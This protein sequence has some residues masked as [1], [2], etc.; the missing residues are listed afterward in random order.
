MSTSGLSGGPW[1]VQNAQR[2]VLL[3]LDGERV[4]WLS[5]SG[6][7][8]ASHLSGRN[9][10]EVRAPDASHDTRITSFV[11]GPS[12]IFFITRDPEGDSL[13]CVTH[14]GRAE[15]IL[16]HGTFSDH[17][18][19]HQDHLYWADLGRRGLVAMPC[20]GG[21]PALLAPLSPAGAGA[22]T[23]LEGEGLVAVS[24]GYVLWTSTLAEPPQ[25]TPLTDE[26][27]STQRSPGR[28]RLAIFR[29][30]MD[31]GPTTVLV[32][33]PHGITD[34]SATD[35]AAVWTASFA[36]EIGMRG[37]IESMTLDGSRT[38]A[39]LQVPDPE[40]RVAT[41]GEMAFVLGLPSGW[42]YPLEI[43]IGPGEGRPLRA[44][45]IAAGRL[46]LVYATE[47]GDI[48]ALA[49]RG[50]PED[51]RA[52]FRR[53]EV[54]A[55]RPEGCREKAA[56]GHETG[57]LDELRAR[58]RQLRAE[59]ANRVP[60]FPYSR[61]MFEP[62]RA[63]RGGDIASDLRT[64]LMDLAL[65]RRGAC[66][67]LTGAEGS[68]K[69]FV[70]H[71]VSA[72]LEARAD[73]P[74]PL[75][76][77]V[78]AH[79]GNAR[80]APTEWAIDELIRAH[81][82]C[83][84]LEGPAARL[85]LE[86]VQRGDVA[87]LLDH[88]DRGALRGFVPSAVARACAALPA[89]STVFVACRSASF[90]TLS[91]REKVLAE[92]SFDTRKADDW[93]LEPFD[94][95]QIWRALWRRAPEQ[96]AAR[97]ALVDADPELLSL[98]RIPFFL[99]ALARLT[100]AHNSH[101]RSSL[102]LADCLAEAAGEELSPFVRFITSSTSRPPAE[103][104]RTPFVTADET[105]AH[106]YFHPLLAEWMCAEAMTIP[107]LRTDG[108][109]E[110]D[111]VMDEMS[112]E[113]WPDQLLRLFTGCVTRVR[114]PSV[115]RHLSEQERIEYERRTGLSTEARNDAVHVR[116]A[117]ILH[118]RLSAWARR[119]A[120]PANPKATEAANA[121]A[122]LRALEALPPAAE[123]GS[124]A[125]P[126]L[127]PGLRIRYVDLRNRDLRGR[128][129]TSSDLSF[130]NL[131]GADLRGAK[132]HGARL[133]GANLL[134]ATLED[135]A[136]DG[137]DTFGAALRLDAPPTETI[138]HHSPVS[139]VSFHPNGL[140]VLTAHWD[141]S[142]KGA[143]QIW[144][145]ES[146][147]CLRA[148]ATAEPV[149]QLVTSPD[150]RTLA[151]AGHSRLRMWDA[152]TLTEKL[153]AS[154]AYGRIAWSPTGLAFA[155]A[156]LVG[157]VHLHDA[158]T[159]RELRVLP[160][161]CPAGAFV[162]V[163]WTDDDRIITS[164]GRTVRV[165]NSNT[166]R[167]LFAFPVPYNVEGLVRIPKSSTIVT[168]S[169]RGMVSFWEVGRDGATLRRSLSDMGYVRDL[170]PSPDG[171]FVALALQNRVGILD[172]RRG[173][174]ARTFAGGG[175]SEV[176]RV[177]WSPDSRLIVAGMLLEH[178]GGATMVWD[179]ETGEATT[180]L[181]AQSRTAAS[182][183]FF[184]VGL[185][186][187]TA[188]EIL[189]LPKAEGSATEAPRAERAMAEEAP[190]PPPAAV[191]CA[192]PPGDA[193][194][195]VPGCAL[196]SVRFR[197][198]G[199]QSCGG[200]ALRPNGD[201]SVFGSLSADMAVGPPFGV[202]SASTWSDFWVTLGEDGTARSAKLVPCHLLTADS[203]G[204]L[205]GAFGFQNTIELEGSSIGSEGAQSYLLYRFDASGH[206]TF[207]KVVTE[208]H[209][210][211]LFVLRLDPFGRLVLGGYLGGSAD[212]GG[213]ACGDA[214]GQ[215]NTGILAWYDIRGQLVRTMLFPG[216]DLLWYQPGP[217]G[218]TLVAGRYFGSANLAGT[219]LQTAEESGR[220]FAK[221]GPRGQKMFVR[222]FDDETYFDMAIGP[223]GHIYL[224]GTLGRGCDFGAGPLPAESAGKLFAV[225]LT[226]DGALVWQKW[227]ESEGPAS[228]GTIALLR[229]GGLFVAGSF[230]GTL[231]L[232]TTPLRA[233]GTGR[234]SVPFA[235]RLSA[236]G[237][238]VWSR[239]YG[240]GELA[241][242][243]GAAV[244]EDGHVVACGVAA[245]D[246]DLG[247][248]TMAGTGRPEVWVAK[249]TVGPNS[250]GKEVA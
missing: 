179:A 102:V 135:G 153:A 144:D 66:V 78:G 147:R 237:D 60:L 243:S 110:L 36:N 169:E 176:L 174:L 151:G 11:A 91:A 201:I 130:S 71:E 211:R 16:A 152:A 65:S 106:S 32:E 13:R 245:G 38:I 103:L 196:W 88:A 197:S 52:T 68:G 229:D 165:W 94:R 73:A 220:F 209:Y 26:P 141:Y 61:P 154:L 238:V 100:A 30:P 173:E 244:A 70:L 187:L 129:L 167:E 86:A 234:N 192:V 42:V 205:A 80:T 85:V 123:E 33:L 225:K 227:W 9:H 233:A 111:G 210:G 35:T 206:L 156:S 203:E 119:A 109:C 171:R 218:S 240:D 228:C 107:I 83:I 25:A 155:A 81:L 2:A 246:L 18:A 178:S 19:I 117:E 54:Q 191:R 142:T 162:G 74:I 236:E 157:R 190:L 113:R 224:A 6:A 140:L 17:L 97:M 82:R 99:A 14:D 116:F 126:A 182:A 59:A 105:G 226:P 27:P 250:P 222:G 21:K 214:E 40:L 75:L 241:N 149:M 185:A 84:G 150:G 37:V 62:V 12:H 115:P 184:A 212:F 193:R 164:V 50:A 5:E 217:D 7:L 138:V 55:Q 249:L 137:A 127:G 242:I 199:D 134:G 29:T 104:L 20:S 4:L 136:L 177:A 63:R 168:A 48:E 77:D 160:D 98:V 235:A 56:S 195:G 43:G 93:Q 248:G 89:T 181:R 121:R 53:T 28:P 47:T 146:G 22:R 219:V 208:T 41:T 163:L 108:R 161:F 158:R 1:L 189:R 69:S 118:E 188:E 51:I 232:G 186:Q 139:A 200:L 112:K 8:R 202:L 15:Q 101:S 204:G 57:V 92:L 143:I 67:L 10:V 247:A 128:D 45:A 49:Q 198:S 125:E 95:T 34:L 39:A 79:L 231:S 114:S 215:R 194:A 166:G 64:E 72:E 23:R 216:L 213:G 223:E 172:E 230:R 180:V 58:Q 122:I 31:G 183:S 175:Y 207:S 145:H 221:Y 170:A 159:H 76:I 124:G 90:S 3:R 44:R 132:L 24:S 148:Q 131:A 96:A 239:A 120:R 87:L 133:V 46:A